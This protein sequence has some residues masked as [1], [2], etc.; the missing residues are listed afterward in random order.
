MGRECIRYAARKLMLAHLDH[1]L[2]FGVCKGASIKIIKGELSR[3]K[4][5]HDVF[6]FD[7]F[8]GLPEDWVG[9]A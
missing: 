6:G 5:K 8:V 9:Q 4:D 1:I 2:E 7:S 3:K